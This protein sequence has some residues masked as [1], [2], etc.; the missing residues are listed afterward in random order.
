MTKAIDTEARAFNPNGNFLSNAD[1]ENAPRRLKIISA[2]TYIG[3]YPEGVEHNEIE[4]LFE[5]NRGEEK[6]IKDK[7]WQLFRVVD[8]LDPDIGDILEI[9][10]VA[11]EPTAQ[12]RVFLNWRASIYRKAN[13]SATTAKTTTPAPKTAEKIATTLKPKTVAPKETA[14]K[15]AIDTFGGEVEDN[16][17]KADEVPF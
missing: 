11:S 8:P 13:A 6:V 12:G 15:A 3:E 10:V 16:E 9:S 2:T 7:F 5:D 1:F 14:V 17:L 4:F